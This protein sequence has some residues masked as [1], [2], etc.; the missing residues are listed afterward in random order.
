MAERPIL[1]RNATVI[2]MDDDLDVLSNCDILIGRN[3]IANIGSELTSEDAEII[4]ATTSIICPG[5]IDTHRHTWQTQLRTLCT[6]DSLADYFKHIRNTF[7]PCYTPQDVFW[8]NYVGALESL[9]AGITYIV[10]H[11]HPGSC[12]SGG[13]WSTRRRDSWHVLVWDVR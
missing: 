7:A 12:G 5:F 3:V 9:N 4:D 1:I 6:D 11:S 2:T 13:Q 8:G 10:D